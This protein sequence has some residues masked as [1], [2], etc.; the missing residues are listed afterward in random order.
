LTISFIRRLT[1][2]ASPTV[3]PADTIHAAG[4][5]STLL[6]Q[7]A[8]LLQAGVGLRGL[9]E[10][11]L[12]KAGQQVSSHACACPALGPFPPRPQRVING[13]RDFGSLDTSYLTPRQADIQNLVRA[14]IRV[15][16]HAI[17]EA[18]DDALSAAGDGSRPLK[19]SLL[20]SRQAAIQ[21]LMRAGIGIKAEAVQQANDGALA[22]AIQES[23][24]RG[25]V[26]P[27]HRESSVFAARSGQ[28][29]RNRAGK[30]PSEFAPGAREN[31]RKHFL[32]QLVQAY[33]FA[34]KNAIA[35][36]TPN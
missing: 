4:D 36:W 19:V 21:D 2:A 1:S 7:R 32:V 35:H 30:S 14:G 10:I 33:V 12:R 27:G 6:P 5:C 13:L 8:P 11:N 20:T 3:G 22:T 26:A 28:R 16:P 29:E 18:N 17:H 23:L 25:L 15:K 9:A 34:F 24:K 31:N